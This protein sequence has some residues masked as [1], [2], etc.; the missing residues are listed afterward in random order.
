VSEQ[1]V[2]LWR[3]SI[4]DFL[5]CRSEADWE[6]WL[7]R[8][9]E[10]WDPDIEW[11]VSATGSEAPDIEEGGFYR[12]REAVR[13]FWREWLAAWETLEFEYELLDAGNR[14]VLLLDQRMRG[15]STGIEVP[16][17]K[18]AQVATFRDGVMTHF[19][20]YA[21]QSEALEAVGLSEQDVHAEG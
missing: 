15:R 20:L 17:G 2:E 21:S 5:A 14:V 16:T 18:Y 9:S 13:R 1:N 6:R 10:L 4:E 3:R 19:K 7:A 11:D 12:G 8:A